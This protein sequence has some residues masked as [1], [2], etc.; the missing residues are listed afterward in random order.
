MYTAYLDNASTGG[1]HMPKAWEQ[2]LP[3][4]VRLALKGLPLGAP[5]CK[6]L[7]QALVILGVELSEYTYHV[8]AKAL[9]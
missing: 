9:R 8:G 3:M 1:N 5:K 7:E 2:S 6:F 4:V